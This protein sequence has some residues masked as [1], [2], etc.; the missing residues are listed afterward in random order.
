MENVT[1]R[2]VR[3]DDAAEI[4]AI[5][6]PYVENTAITFEYEAPDAREIGRRIANTVPKYPYIV[7]EKDGKILGYAYAHGFR[8]RAAY[9]YSVETSIYVA[10]DSHGCGIGALLYDDLE[11]LLRGQGFLNMNAC[12]TVAAKGSECDPHITD[13]SVRFHEKLGFALVG[14]FQKCGYKF[15]RWYDMIWMEKLIGEHTAD[16]ADLLPF[17][18]QRK[19]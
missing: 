11:K 16:P 5:Y 14:R 12:I 15:G 3:A 6:R 9:M 7:A 18:T 1:V 8:E 19:L 2:P 10:A 13:G 17:D 4:A